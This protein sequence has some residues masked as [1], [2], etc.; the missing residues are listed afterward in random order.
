MSTL[1]FPSLV[2]FYF[3]SRPFHNASLFR[4]TPEAGVAWV[5][6]FRFPFPSSH[7]VTGLD[8]LRASCRTWTGTTIRSLFRELFI[9]SLQNYDPLEF[10]LCNLKKKQ[11]SIS[12]NWIVQ[13]VMLIKFTI[14][15]FRI[16]LGFRIS[17]RYIV[18][19]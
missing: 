7:L 4:G 13:V 1:P 17:S 6:S 19:F 2:P 11:S 5:T 18:K 14:L 9:L 15:S 16:F 3:S 12:R 10:T 8:F